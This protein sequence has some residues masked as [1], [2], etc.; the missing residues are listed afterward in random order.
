MI[1]PNEDFL[2][3]VLIQI[4]LSMRLLKGFS[5]Q[6][7]GIYHQL[8]SVNECFWQHLLAVLLI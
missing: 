4:L 8:P 2:E 6:P 7:D 5:N 1:N 3:I